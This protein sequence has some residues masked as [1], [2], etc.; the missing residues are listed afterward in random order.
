[1][2][3]GRGAGTRR[4]GLG[5][6]VVGADGTPAS[7][8]NLPRRRRC[9]AAPRGAARSAHRGA[10][11][12]RGAGRVE[13][14]SHRAAA[15]RRVRVS[16]PDLRRG[17]PAPAQG[18]GRG[19]RTASRGRHSRGRGG[20]PGAGRPHGGFPPVAAPGSAAHGAPRDH[21]PQRRVPGPS[22]C[23]NGLRRPG[24]RPRRPAHRSQRRGGGAVAA[25]L[26]RRSGGDVTS[27]AVEARPARAAAQQQIALVDLLDRL[28][29]TGVVLS[30][31]I[32]ISLA[33]VDLVQVSLRAL[34]T[35]VR[36]EMVT[37]P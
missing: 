13:C 14:E 29:G 33:G 32:V 11:P 1:M 31:D 3:R 7:G 34:I 22:R 25:L 23:R 26:L 16:C 27:S 2:A 15:W 5:S 36:A 20:P 10:G 28:L 30:G 8:N 24:A 21:G 37:V 6:G 35:T 18:R 4:R 17:V 9:A 12:C 19:A